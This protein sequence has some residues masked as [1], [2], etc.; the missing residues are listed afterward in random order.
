[1]PNASINLG[2]NVTMLWVGTVGSPSS[3]VNIGSLAGTSASVLEGGVD[4]GRTMIWGVGTDNASAVFAG[5]IAE[6]G[7]T[8][9]T[10][11]IKYGTGTWTLSGPCNYN[12][13]TL[14]SAGAL[15]VSGTI[16]S[17]GAF[18]VKQGATLNLAGGSIATPS[19]TIDPGASCTAYGTIATTTL[20]N[21]GSF[22][23]GA[24][25]TLTISGNAVN[26]GIMSFTGGASLS[27]SG[28]FT[29][30]GILDLL[31]GSQTLPAN[32]VNY[33]TIINSTSV[34]V[35]TMT[36]SGAAMSVTIQSY[37]GHT[38]TLQSSNSI[39]NPS[40]Q[41]V[42]AQAGNGSTLTLTDPTG[43]TGT[44]KFYRVSIAP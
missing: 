9:I 44:A 33:G 38:Y 2:N 37:S 41:Q 29:N 10:S 36:K 17:G 31:T 18:E 4:G 43:A 27:I 6:Q 13:T 1:M 21:N 7:S 12:G 26:N 8:D 14:V 15:L 23:A 32:L 30:N 3:Q 28:T 16:N 11:L 20:I 40:W 34:K 25:H 42:T 39:S 5:S 24:G 19:L 35:L 22:G